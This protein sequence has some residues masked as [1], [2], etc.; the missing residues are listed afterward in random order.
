LTILTRLKA[1][2]AEI[3]RD[4]WRFI[5]KRGRLTNEALEWVKAH[6]ADACREAWPAFD[7]WEERA[8]IREYEGG[9]TREEAER[10]AYVDVTQ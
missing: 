5:L 8:A 9:E 3:V 1:H 10:W 2:G 6:W 7:D 4:D